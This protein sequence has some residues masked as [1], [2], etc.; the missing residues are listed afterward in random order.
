MMNYI[1]ENLSEKQ[2]R[3]TTYLFHEFPKDRNCQFL[4]PK[5]QRDM[6]G[7]WSL[8]SIERW[9]LFQNKTKKSVKDTA[10]SK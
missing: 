2:V 4:E 6:I 7:N 9:S 1:L 8:H 10:I 3:L 5:V